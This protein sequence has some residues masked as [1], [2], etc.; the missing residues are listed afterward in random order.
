[1]EMPSKYEMHKNNSHTDYVTM[2]SLLNTGFSA[3]ITL[4]IFLNLTSFAVSVAGSLILSNQ[5]GMQVIAGVMY[6]M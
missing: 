5:R 2:V 4:N 3:Q 1:M 6:Q